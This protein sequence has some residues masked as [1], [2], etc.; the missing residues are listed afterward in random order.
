MVIQEEIIFHR[1]E[2]L[3]ET[4]KRIFILTKHN[5]TL[6][7]IRERF[8]TNGIDKDQIDSIQIEIE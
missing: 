2:I 8:G 3:Q 6:K 7:D 4:P 1:V 5:A